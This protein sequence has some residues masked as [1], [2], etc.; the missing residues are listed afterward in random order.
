MTPEEAAR[1]NAMTDI[2]I[3]AERMRLHEQQNTQSQL[4]AANDQ[5]LRDL[6]YGYVIDPNRRTPQQIQQAMRDGRW[7]R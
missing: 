3:E 7:T 6:G 1:I 4:R 5:L 2:E